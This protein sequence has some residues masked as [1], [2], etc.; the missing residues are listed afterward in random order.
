[1]SRSSIARWK[2]LRQ[3]TIDIHDR[4]RLKAIRERGMTEIENLAARNRVFG[5]ACNVYFASRKVARGVRE[6]KS[7]VLGCS[8]GEVSGACRQPW[9]HSARIADG[10]VWRAHTSMSAL[11]SG[12]WRSPLV[13]R[14]IGVYSCQTFV[15]FF[16]PM[17]RTE[18]VLK[19]TSP[20]SSAPL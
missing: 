8:F 15:L 4:S 14:K 18:F 10:E 6:S 13:W 5:E 16:Q 2:A 11:R 20:A 9:R 17:K 19:Q 1:M 12:L 3:K 7:I